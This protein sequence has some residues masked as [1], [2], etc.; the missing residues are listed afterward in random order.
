MSKTSSQHRYQ[1]LKDW[2]DYI[3]KTAKRRK[4]RSASEVE[5]FRIQNRISEDV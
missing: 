4:T 3:Y 5:A 2:L 1:C